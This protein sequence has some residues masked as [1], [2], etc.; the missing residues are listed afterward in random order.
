MKFLKTLFKILG[1]LIVLSVV[2]FTA[3]WF[4]RPTDVSFEEHKAKIPNSEYSKFI[5]VDGIKL[6]Y[7]EK[8]EG[9]PLVLIHGYGSSTYTW[10]DVFVPLSENFR[11]IAVDLKGFGFSEKPDG[12]YTRNAQA[13]LVQKFLDK[14]KIEKAHFAGSSMGGEVSLNVALQSSERVESLILV[15]SSGVKSVKGSGSTPS[16]FE[17]PFVG[18]AFVALALLSDNLVRTSLERSYFDDS[19]VTKELVETYH[20][21]LQTNNGQRAAVYTQ[22]QWDLYPIEDDLSKVKVPTL[23]IWGEEDFVTPLEG[24]KKMNASM[25]DSKLVVFENCGHLPAEEMPK[26]TV[27]EILKF[28]EKNES[29][30]N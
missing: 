12:D 8:G 4:S 6:H 18:R 26:R 27:E 3:F 9:T 29:E 7:Q 16:R 15:D 2:G 19:K 10:R 22:Q 17:V 25:E 13:V 23:I 30:D 11:V 24:G 20:L 5:E 28:T 1:V 14:L 21:P